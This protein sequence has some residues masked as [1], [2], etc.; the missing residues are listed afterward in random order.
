MRRASSLQEGASCCR[1]TA[2]RFVLLIFPRGKGQFLTGR[3]EGCSSAAKF[4]HGTGG[5]P[6]GAETAPRS[7]HKFPGYRPRKFTVCFAPF[8]P[9]RKSRD[10]P[11]LPGGCREGCNAVSYTHLLA[12]DE[13]L[14]DVSERADVFASYSEDTDLKEERSWT[15]E[16]PFAEKGEE[17]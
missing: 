8:E 12:E 2:A 16:N 7:N 5:T 13:E 15:T 4:Q 11:V 6:R 17:A 1:Y 3:L 14:E 9:L 10:T